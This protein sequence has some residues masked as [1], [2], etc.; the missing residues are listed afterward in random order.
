MTGWVRCEIGSQKGDDFVE[1]PDAPPWVV[2]A[3]S[4]PTVKSV[5]IMYEDGSYNEWRRKEDA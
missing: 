1:V 2:V 4:S 5:R 3:L